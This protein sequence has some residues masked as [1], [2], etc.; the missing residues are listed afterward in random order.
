MVSSTLGSPT[1]TGWKRRS[2]AASFSMCLR[3][4]SRVVAPMQRS[5]PR[6]SA[7]FSMLA[8]SA[9]P[10][11]APAPTIVCSSS[12]KRITLALRLGDLAQH[13]LQA[14][15]ELAAVLG[16]G[17]HRADVER[18]EPA[19]RRGSPARRRPRCAGRG[20]R[21]SRSC[22][23]RA[24]RSA[25]GCS[26][27]A[28]RAPAPRGGSPRRARPRDRACRLRAT[29]VRSRPNLARAW[30]FDSGSGS[31][32]RALPRT[33]SMP[34]ATASGVAPARLQ[35]AAHLVVAVLGQRE[36]QDLRRD[37]LVLALLGV[38]ER[39]LEH[40]RERGREARLGAARHLRQAR[41]APS[42][43]WRRPASGT[44]SFC[45]IGTTAPSG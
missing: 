19:V 32:T 20:P 35:Q 3:Y 36:Q 39:R 42:S 13:R 1:S 8:A 37:V 15:L 29:S 24:R 45:R 28:A 12:M 25:P 2:R 7:G 4:S 44:P 27:C 22:R 31:V 6:A 11:A 41:S 9:A 21:R 17:D 5:S 26:W 10:S 23:R 43:C 18:D 34:L 38:L 40:A 33:A 14:V 16:A 30:Y